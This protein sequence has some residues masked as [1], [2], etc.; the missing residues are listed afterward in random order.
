MKLTKCIMGRL[1][2]LPFTQLNQSACHTF[3]F[4]LFSPYSFL[5]THGILIVQNEQWALDIVHLSWLFTYFFPFLGFSFQPSKYIFLMHLMQCWF[6]L[7][8]LNKKQTNKTKQAK[9]S[10]TTLLQDTIFKNIFKQLTVIS[11]SRF[12]VTVTLIV[13]YRIE[14]AY[15][16]EKNNENTILFCSVF[17]SNNFAIKMAFNINNFAIIKLFYWSYFSFI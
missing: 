17:V 3:A 14:R 5:I 16:T 12:A 11:I 15:T 13:I 6:A 10:R 9:C 8:F 1:D 2:Y 4:C 7:C